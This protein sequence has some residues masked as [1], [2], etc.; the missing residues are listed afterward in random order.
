MWGTGTPGPGEFAWNRFMPR[1][2]LHVDMDAFYTSVEQ[3]DHPEY[4]GKPVIVGADPKGGMGRGV[5]AAA[6][7]EA[8]SFGVHSAMPIGRAYRLCPGGVYLRGDMKKYA[9]ASKRIMSILHSY[10]DFVEPI[11]I[12][13]AFLDVSAI[14]APD[15]G[16]ALAREIKENIWASE[17]LRASI[18]TASN[19]FLAKIASDLEKPDGLVAVPA[20]GELDFLKELPVTRLWG[21]GPKTAQRLHEKGFHKISDLWKTS[22]NELGL[23][24]LGEH[25]WKL[26]RGIDDRDVVPH[27]EA[28]SIG[29]ETTFAEDISDL[30]VVHKTLLRLADAVA[31]RLRK[32]GVRGSTVTLKF[33]DERFVTETRAR[34]L[35]EPID[36]AGEIYRTALAQ[37]DRVEVRGRKVRLLG[38][39]LSNL[40]PMG[41]PRQLTLF[42]REE[43]D[44]KLSRAR[45]RLESRF[46][47]GSVARASLLEETSLHPLAPS[48]TDDS[49]E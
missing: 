23:G 13:E 24:K 10:T 37:L 8:R 34:T 20:G 47:K 30:D 3:R 46:G 21:V 19:K 17:E 11:S 12:D 7:Y 48:G 40:T 22:P 39:S 26:S 36:D 28:K 35:R 1:T 44:D 14:A 6:S 43:K 32:H 49:R 31:V 45:D 4:L 2:I 18:G 16:V 27:H 9:S 29:H 42:G 25:L 5:V 41:A 38:I 33:R 15:Q